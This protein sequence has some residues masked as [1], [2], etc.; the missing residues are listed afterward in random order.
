M[1]A[2]DDGNALDLPDTGGGTILPADLTTLPDAGDYLWFRGQR[3]S[4]R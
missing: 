1:T 2:D 4:V 3:G